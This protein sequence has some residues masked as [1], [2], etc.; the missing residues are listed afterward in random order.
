MRRKGTHGNEAW[1]KGCDKKQGGESL[2]V[3]ARRKFVPARI[4]GHNLSP[5]LGFAY[6]NLVSPAL[7]NRMISPKRLASLGKGGL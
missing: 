1:V 7:L 5:N 6:L 3:R 4:F 2:D